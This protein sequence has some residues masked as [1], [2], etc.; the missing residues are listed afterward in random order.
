LR[1]GFA[2]RDELLLAIFDTVIAEARDAL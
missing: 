2:D 1:T